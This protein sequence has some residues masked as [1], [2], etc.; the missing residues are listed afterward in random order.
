MAA[1]V[2]S[3]DSTRRRPGLTRTSPSAGEVVPFLG[4]RYQ[5]IVEADETACTMADPPAD[6]ADGGGTTRRRC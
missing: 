2:L 6:P 4:V 1:I 5:R 3:F